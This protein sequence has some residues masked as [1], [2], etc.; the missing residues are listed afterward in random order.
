MPKNTAKELYRKLEK[1]LTARPFLQRAGMSRKDMTALLNEM[2]WKDTVSELIS[3]EDISCSR[4]LDIC[5]PTLDRMT[6]EPEQGW[7]SF[8]FDRTLEYLFPECGSDETGLTNQI[9]EQKRSGTLFL[10]ETLHTVLF[11]NSSGRKFSPLLDFELIDET[12]ASACPAGDEYMKMLE[13]AREHYLY[14]FMKIGAEITPFNTLGHVAGVHYVAMHVGK[15]LVQKDVPVDIAMVSASAASHD[16]GKFGC[17]KNEAS[18][19][20]YLHYYYTDECLKRVGMPMVA[21][22]A[23]NHSTWDLELENLSA[24]SLILI[25]ADF[26]VKSDRDEM[27]RERINFYTLKEAFDVILNKLDNV[28]EAKKARY[29]RVYEKLHD[30]EEYMKS[31]GVSVDLDRPEPS[32]KKWKDAALLDGEGSVQRLKYLAIEHNIEVMNKF[33]SQIDFGNL[34]EDARSEKQWKN[35]RAYINTLEEYFTYMTLTQ[36]QMTIGFLT[37][38]LI[39][40]EGD[41]RRQAAALTGEII[42][43]YDEEYRKEIPEGRQNRKNKIDSIFIW[44]E[45][46]KYIIYPDLQKTERQKRWMGYSLKITLNSLIEEAETL[47][48]KKKYLAEFYRMADIRNMEDATVFIMLDTLLEAPVQLCEKRDIEKTVKFCE[49]AIKRDVLEIKVAVL[50]VIRHVAADAEEKL[51]DGKTVERMHT[52]LKE[53]VADDETVSVVYLKVKAREA[54]GFRGKT[55][56]RFKDELS[57]LQEA[58]NDIFRDNLKVGTPWT[59]KAV[60]I[61]LML[62]ELRNGKR[63]EAFYIATHL[64]NLLKVSERVTVRHSAGRGLIE[65]FRMLT[66]DQRNEIVIELTKGLEIGEYQFS[67]YIPEYLGVLIMTLHPDELDEI[68]HELQHLLESS[69]DKVAS[70]TLDTLGVM[71]NNYAGY[72]D[73]F[74]ETEKVYTRRK[75]KIIG[76][77]LCGMANYRE[78]VSQEAFMVLGQNIFGSEHMT[79][80]QKFDIFRRFYK[81]MLTLVEEKKE[82]P[83]RFFNNAAALN[84][85]YRFISDYH[86]YVG[87]PD[88]KESKK[89]AFF[90]ARSIRF[91]SVTR[92]S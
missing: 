84:H 41:I 11:F 44:K 68:M 47:Q 23:S 65:L 80:E 9:T 82:E 29:I 89:A 55:T 12:R 52:I 81:K 18:R 67:K 22:I 60:N 74:S 36:K 2:N 85:I 35:I 49:E 73:Q 31:I 28:D 61:E 37:E 57:E 54:L 48:E 56:G 7:L 92:G 32:E 72:K 88:L 19:I 62:D 77:L 6:A 24:E 15:Q 16:I 79:L 90:P 42:A 63:K 4:I 87:E 69:N 46:L 39:N 64:S 27:G 43:C 8:L 13:L 86:F 38:L 20:P 78:P 10:E 50:R 51:L 66:W 1:N 91:L 45:Y 26:R 21:H 25:Y 83:L 71:L 34:L 70:V 53:K 59:I 5:R 76:M 14:E 30:F 17:K 3:S 33:G 75:E 40:R 58:T